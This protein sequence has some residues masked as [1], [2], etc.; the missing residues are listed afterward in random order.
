LRWGWRLGLS[1][2][3]QRYRRAQ[4]KQRHQSS[5]FF[6][7][8]CRS[9]DSAQSLSLFPL[10]AVLSMEGDIWARSMSCCHGTASFQFT[11]AY[12]FRQGIAAFSYLQF[13]ATLAPALRIC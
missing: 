4:A 13:V 10:L 12:R 5:K 11:V 7:A 9:P 3:R 1:C 6:H 2:R 8:F